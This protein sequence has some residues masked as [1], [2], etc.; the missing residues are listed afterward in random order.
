[1]LEEK[2]QV[3]GKSQ[4]HMYKTNGRHIVKTVLPGAELCIASQTRFSYNGDDQ[5]TCA[6]N[7]GKAKVNK[8]HGV[9]QSPIST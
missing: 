3:E 1:M 7:L 8:A 2:I 5:L 6:T 4:V 9:P